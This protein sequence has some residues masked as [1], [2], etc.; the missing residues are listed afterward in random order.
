M[1]Q[2][3]PIKQYILTPTDMFYFQYLNRKFETYPFITPPTSPF[4]MHH[5]S[6]LLDRSANILEHPCHRYLPV[7]IKNE[8]VKAH[9]MTC[10]MVDLNTGY[11]MI[12]LQC[13]EE[14]EEGTTEMGDGEC[15]ITRIG[16]GHYLVMV[17]NPCCFLAR[18]LNKNGCFLMAA[19]PRTDT[20]I[21]WSLV[22]PSSTALNNLLKDMKENGYTYLKQS[23][24]NLSAASTLT[25]RQEECFN[26]AMDLGYYDVPKRIGLD[27]LCKVLDCSKS[28]LNVTLRSAEKR[29]FDFYRMF[30]VSNRFYKN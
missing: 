16:T 15:N 12:D 18:L 29:I 9:I 10:S 3:Y 26:L 13:H 21:E 8:D 25:Q 4:F 17:K 30:C 22:G 28:T 6:I 5:C 27:E 23:S 2:L 14:L 20:L 11:S 7:D 1:L 24:N 19:V